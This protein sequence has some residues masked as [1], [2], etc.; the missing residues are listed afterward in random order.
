M[1]SKYNNF[2]YTVCTVLLFFSW[3]AS[4]IIEVCGLHIWYTALLWL[5][6]GI[7]FTK[8]TEKIAFVFEPHFINL[9]LLYIYIPFITLINHLC[10]VDNL[11]YS[12]IVP[13]S[14]CIMMI[15]SC[16]AFA[17]VRNKMLPLFL[18]LFRSFMTAS[19]ILGFYDFVTRDFWYEPIIKSLTAIDN[20]RKYCY[21][22]GSQAYRLTMF[23]YHPIF[24][25]MLLFAAIATAVFFPRKNIIWRCIELVLFFSNLILTQGRTAMGITVLLLL[26]FIFRHREQIIE[27]RL[28]LLVLSLICAVTFLYLLVFHT[29]LIHDVAEMIL[30]RLSSTKKVFWGTVR[31]NNWKIV[32]DMWKEGNFFHIIFGGGYLFGYSFLQNHPLILSLPTTTLSWT[33]AIDNQYIT[34]LM[35]CGIVGTALF[36]YYIVSIIRLLFNVQDIEKEFLCCIILGI[37]ISGITYEFMGHNYVFYL[38]LI[39]SA[40][41][42]DTDRSPGICLINFQKKKGLI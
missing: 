10:G 26:Y 17:G 1:D 13:L 18:Q 31:S 11:Y 2:N 3:I 35:D 30:T 21:F 22:D 16:M 24:Y 28:T 32:R 4:L 20:F 6:Y 40:M 38:Y 19:C 37:S 42:I 14:V 41:L 33:K 23:F 39:F 29:S 25:S 34:L 5:L 12:K 36:V 27:Y 15:P 7:L 8:Y 9:L